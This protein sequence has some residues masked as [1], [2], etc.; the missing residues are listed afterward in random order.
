METARLASVQASTD[1]SRQ[2][3]DLAYVQPSFARP[4][5]ERF[6]AHAWGK[7]ILVRSPVLPGPRAQITNQM[8]ALPP[9]V[10]D[11]RL[12]GIEEVQIDGCRG[13]RDRR[14]CGRQND[15]EA[16]RCGWLPGRGN[17]VRRTD[18]PR[19]EKSNGHH[20]GPTHGS[21]SLCAGDLH[22]RGV[23][24]TRATPTLLRVAQHESRLSIAHRGGG[25]SS[26]LERRVSEDGALPELGAEANSSK[27][28]M[29][30]SKITGYAGGYFGPGFEV[31]A[32]GVVVL[33]GRGR[34]PCVDRSRFSLILLPTSKRPRRRG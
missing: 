6:P 8:L 29:G 20:L 32:D 1:R 9:Q 18:N 19:K 12:P 13:R 7:G 4:A 28:H 3:A 30:R 22:G 31:I 14:R 34:P 15:R 33:A 24:Q 25:G 11:G 5:G 17:A 10:I 26:Y 23:C 2:R 27:T 21:P 16:R